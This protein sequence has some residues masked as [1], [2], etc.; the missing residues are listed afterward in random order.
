MWLGMS[1]LISLFRKPLRWDISICDHYNT[2]FHI[3]MNVTTNKIICLI[4]G[5]AFILYVIS[6]SVC[7][8]D[9]G[10]KLLKTHRPNVESVTTFTSQQRAEL[11]QQVAQAIE[12]NRLDGNYLL[13]FDNAPMLHYITDMK[14]YLGS[15]WSYFW[16]EDMFKRQLFRSENSTRP[17]PLIAVPKFYYSDLS[18]IDYNNDVLL[19]DRQ[20]GKI[21][22]LYHFMQ[23][24]NYAVVHND[25]Y[26]TLYAPHI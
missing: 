15:P 12:Q 22:A 23:R 1:M 13:V 19:H 7:Y 9:E 16:G 21:E 14:P 17:L 10:S 4:A 6:H 3:S 25:S 5:I 8:F 11:T 2:H 20:S 26:I 18:Y 24:Y